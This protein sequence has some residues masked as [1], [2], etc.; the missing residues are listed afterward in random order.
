MRSL[1][2]VMLFASALFAQAAKTKADPTPPRKV[3][4][5]LRARVTQFLNYH[6]TG[7]F[8]KAEALV[9]EDTK[10]DFYNR[11]KPRYVNC[12]GI[13]T[14]RYSDHFTKAYVTALCTIPMLIQPSDNEVDS[15]GRPMM[16]MG[17]P[18]VPLPS[19][20]KLEKGKWCMYLDKNQ[21][22]I[23]PFG[24]MPSL[25]KGQPIAPGTVLPSVAVPPGVVVPAPPPAFSDNPP[26]QASTADPGMLA[27]M[28]AVHIPTTAASVGQVPEAAL[29]H[30]K[31][32][33][34]TVTLKAG[35]SGQVKISNDADDMR[36]LMVLGQVAGIEAKLEKP[37]VKGGDSVLLNLKAGDDAKSGT[38]NIVVLTTGE[39][40]P[41]TVT[42]K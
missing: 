41:V 1:L 2:A 12:K 19:T 6:I 26:P 28:R 7:E 3:D 42:V 33:P 39:M 38:L 27:A 22:R 18:T 36:Q 17:P 4:E 30:V 16:P 11:P 40:L 24:V 8:R 32:K 23:T 25:P 14:I 31:L 34:S 20:W 29:H 5:A 35:E 10:D 21:D 15:D 9:A 13:S 37:G